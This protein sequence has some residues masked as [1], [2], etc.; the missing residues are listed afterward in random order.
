MTYH[1][2]TDAELTYLR[3]HGQHSKL[4]LA[5]PQPATIFAAVVNQ[6]FDT[7]DMVDKFIYD[8]E[9]A[10][11]FNDILPGMTIWVGSAAGLRDLGMCRVRKAAI[12]HTIYIGETSEIPWAE[13]LYITVK[14]DFSLWPKH[15][16]RASD[17]DHTVFM[18]KDIPYTDQHADFDPCPVLGPDAVLF[19]QG[20]LGGANTV[21]V[22]FDASDSWVIGSTIDSYDW[23]APG[24]SAVADDHTATPTFTYDTPGTYRVSCLVTADN[25]KSFTGYRKVLVY[26]LVSPPVTQFT[27]QSCSGD[28]QAGGWQFDVDLFDTTELASV[29]PQSEVFLFARD[30]Y[31]S[32]IVKTGDTIS[33]DHDT[34]KI[35]DSANGMAIFKAGMTIQV[36][37]STSN[38][39]IYHVVTGNTAGFVV[40]AEHIITEAA[41][42]AVTVA[43]LDGATEVSLG[44]VTDRENIICHGWVSYENLYVNMQGG[45]ASF[46]VQGPHYWLDNME[47]FMIGFEQNLSPSEWIHFYP[48]TVDKALWHLLHWRSTATAMMDVRLTGDTRYCTAVEASVGSLWQQMVT[49]STEYILAKPCVDRYGC[50]YV[51]IESEYQNTATRAASHG[52]AVMDILASDYGEEISIEYRPINAVNQLSLSGMYFDGTGT[53]EN[54]LGLTAFAALANGH[55]FKRFGHNETVDRIVLWASQAAANELAGLIATARNNPYPIISVELAQNNRFLDICPQYYVTLTI[56]PDNVPRG[57]NIAGFNLFV[58]NVELYYNPETHAFQTQLS[59]KV[60]NKVNG[61]YADLAVTGDLPIN[62]VDPEIPPTTTPWPTYPP[63]PPYPTI[64]TYAAPFMSVASLL[65]AD[66]SVALTSGVPQT[67]TFESAT[68]LGDALQWLVDHQD[69]VLIKQYGVYLAHLQLTWNRSSGGSEPYTL[70]I[71]I[72]ENDNPTGF[73][74]FTMGGGSYNLKS[75]WV[76]GSTILEKINTQIIDFF[77]PDSYI[78][79]RFVGHTT[80]NINVSLVL[81]VVQLFKADQAV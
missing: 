64:P 69:Q 40:V 55:S 31:G 34:K 51:Q 4:Y 60:E 67:V 52:A 72:C 48:P 27:L 65:F 47:G 74:T 13:D 79:V 61:L 80:M 41:G 24:A 75:I 1:H 15:I 22:H 3:S 12:E 14:D 19:Y 30:W 43:E 50:L 5:F 35:L 6:T 20:T 26:D 46:T 63:L 11:D 66:P 38:N 53:V 49:M 68:V 32:Q 70:G 39:G 21:H 81:Q 33:F 16:Y 37:G 77:V 17:A 23:S 44:Q 36:T 71:Q 10:Y 56:D 18:D 73:W 8:G 57:L 29:I 45:K 58:E 76:G 2:I 9:G 59:L 62:N 54:G 28:V 25:G 42:D 7:T 78:T